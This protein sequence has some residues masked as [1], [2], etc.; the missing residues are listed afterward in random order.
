VQSLSAR[1]A[2]YGP[3]TAARILPSRA[4]E[5][6][7][8]N[9]AV[10]LGRDRSGRPRYSPPVRGRGSWVPV[11]WS[12][13]ALAAG[14][15]PSTESDDPD[16]RPRSAGEN[17]SDAEPWVDEGPFLG[18][19]P[20]SFDRVLHGEFRRND[21][22][23]T[24]L[25][26]LG[27]DPVQ[28]DRV[29]RALDGLVDLTR[30]RV[31]HEV[32]LHTTDD[33]Q[34]DWFRYRAS[35]EDRFVAV[36]SGP[37]MTSYR[38]YVPVRVEKV[39]VDGEVEVSLYLAMEAIGEEPWLTLTLAD[40]FAWDIDFFTETRE[41]DR[42]KIW[43]EKRYIEDRFIGYGRVLGAE[44]AQEDGDVFQA[45]RY[46]LENG[47]TGYYTAEG[48]AVEKQFLKSPVKFASITSRYGL[49]R[50]P[51]LKYVRAHKGVDYGAPRGTAVWSVGDGVVTWAARRGG[52]GRLVQIR[53]ANGL[54]TRY[55]HLKAYGRGIRKGKRVRQK[56][57][58]GYVGASGLATGPHLH[59]EVLRRG[60]HVNPLTLVVPPA[61]PIP[62]EER[63]RFGAAVAPVL[64]AL[65]GPPSKVSRL[66]R[67]AAEADGDASNSGGG[68]DPDQTAV[69]SMSK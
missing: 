65:D 44:Y 42:F 49:R 22:L 64:A 23:S 15:G 8:R 6:A 2:P 38:E 17:A 26:R 68:A 27:V 40:L 51:V 33:G 13:W 58:I 16:P 54:S 50:H 24:V 63:E 12:C 36:G 62:E 56:Q 60:R 69:T 57:V 35:E 28:V 43:V 48:Q 53:H 21:S 46:T 39:R 52:Y 20:L 5:A 30:I 41:G 18:P 34:V 9:F 10:R 19:A 11:L 14:C 47:Q 7:G 29:A 37:Q 55:A 66:A 31:G 67:A 25:E 45:L 4:S 1:R 3:L 61:P 32:E 59:F